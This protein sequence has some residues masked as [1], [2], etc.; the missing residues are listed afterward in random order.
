MFFVKRFDEAYRD[1]FAN[2]DN[3]ELQMMQQNQNF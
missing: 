3:L 2:Y 1:L